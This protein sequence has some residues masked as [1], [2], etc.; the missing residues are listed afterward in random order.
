MKK[1]ILIVGASGHARVIVDIV[2][3]AGIYEIAGILDKNLPIGS[4]FQGYEVLGTDDEGGKFAGKVDGTLIAIG[5]NAVRARVAEKVGKFLPFVTAVHPAATVARGVEIGEGTVV[6]AGARINP[7]SVIGRFCILNTSSS[8]D[9]DCTLANYASL[10]P[11]VVTGGNCHV[12]EFSAVSIG[13]VVKHG[14]KIGA[15]TVIGAGAV[16]LGD[17][18]ANTVAYGCPARIVRKR[19]HGEKYL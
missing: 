11:G 16:V 3:C 2:E 10:A 13:A 9:H 15:E 8:L 19:N 18:E 12:G 5:D 7:G 6:M 17:I 14:V 1:K 4:R